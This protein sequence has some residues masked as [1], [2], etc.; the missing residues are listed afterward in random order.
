MEE[1]DEYKGRRVEYSIEVYIGY[2]KCF[3]RINI[4][5]RNVIL[6]IC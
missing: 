5:K 2:I 1:L 6:S 3:C 4:D